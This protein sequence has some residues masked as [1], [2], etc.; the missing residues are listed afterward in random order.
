MAQIP[1]PRRNDLFVHPLTGELFPADEHALQ[2]AVNAADRE[3]SRL[4]RGTDGLRAKLAE[5]RGP[6]VLPDGV[7]RTDKQK[8]IARCPRCMERTPDDV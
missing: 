7:K 5:I 3:I 2:D 1:D 6:A 4:Y 8:R